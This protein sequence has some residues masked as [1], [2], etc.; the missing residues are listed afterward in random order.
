MCVYIRLL[1]LDTGGRQAQDKQT[2]IAHDA[3]VGRGGHGYPVVIVG[4]VLHGIWVE[5]LRAKLEHRSHGWELKDLVGFWLSRC[6]ARTEVMDVDHKPRLLG[7]GG[8]ADFGPE[9]QSEQGSV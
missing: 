3:E 1:D 9:I 6:E 4:G 8:F 7:C 5:A 2:A